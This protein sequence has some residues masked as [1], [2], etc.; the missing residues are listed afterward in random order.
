ML[1][2]SNY[3]LRKH[4]KTKSDNQRTVLTIKDVCNPFFEMDNETFFL[5][6]AIDKKSQLIEYCSPGCL[7]FFYDKLQFFNGETSRPR[8]RLFFSNYTHLANKLYPLPTNL[9][10]IY[11]PM[12]GYRTVAGDSREQATNFTHCPAFWNVFKVEAAVYPID[13]EFN[14]CSDNAFYKQ[15][16]EESIDCANTERI[17]YFFITAGAVLIITMYGVW[18]IKI[19]VKRIDF[20]LTKSTYE[21]EF[22]IFK[23][24]HSKEKTKGRFG[25]CRQCLGDSF[26]NSLEVLKGL[27]TPL[28]LPNLSIVMTITKQSVLF[29]LAPVTEALDI[30]LDGIYIVRLSRILNRFWIKA[31]IIKLMLKLYMVAVVKDVL[32]HFL[33]LLL[34][35]KDSLELSP[36]KNF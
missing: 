33:I 3:L 9:R 6:F 10:T 5:N 14:M 11:R 7:D 16:E 2:F 8:E 15:S 17:G 25:R 28:P 36:Q 30:V 26:K 12:M 1:H 24:K 32:F 23:Y 20:Q 31:K 4:S 18:F 19:F 27:L 22:N 13:D 29:L 34:L 21:D 35:F